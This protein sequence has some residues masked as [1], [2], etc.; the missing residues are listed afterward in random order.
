MDG[1][2]RVSDHAPG[3]YAVFRDYMGA[4]H[5][6]AAVPIDAASGGAALTPAWNALIETSYMIL[7]EAQCEATGLS[8]N[9]YVPALSHSAGAG[10]TGCSGSGT[11]ADEYGAEAARTGW[12]LA[13]HWLLHGD[14]RAALFSRRTAAHVASKLGSFAFSVC[15]SV[16]SCAALQLDTGC[17]I[18]SI[19]PSWVWNGFMLGPTAASLV[20][21]PAHSSALPAQRLAINNAALVLDAMSVDDYY[22]GSWVAIATATLSGV[23]T[24]LAPLVQRLAQTGLPSPPTPLPL[25][26]LLPLPRLPPPPPSRPPSPAAAPTACTARFATCG[27]GHAPCC[28]STA[29]FRQS[30]YYSQCLLSCPVDASPAWACAVPSPPHPSPAESPLPPP[31][32]PVPPPVPQAPVAFRS[33][34]PSPSLPPSPSPS[35]SPLLSASPPPQPPPSSSPSPPLSLPPPSLSPSPAPSLPSLAPSPSPLSLLPSLALP[36]REPPTR[37]PAFIA[38]GFD[39]AMRMTEYQVI[40]TTTAAGAVETF[41]RSSFKRRLAAALPGVRPDDITLRVRAASVRVEAYVSARNATDA[42]AILATLQ[43]LAASTD[44]LS[45]ALGVAVEAVE[46]PLIRITRHGLPAPAAPLPPKGPTSYQM[47]ES[48]ARTSTASSSGAPLA[49]G[50][51]VGALCLLAVV[52]LVVYRRMQHKR[53]SAGRSKAV[54]V[55][56]APGGPVA[57]S[58]RESSGLA[59]DAVPLDSITP[60]PAAP[61]RQKSPHL[62]TPRR[63]SKCAH[64]YV[65]DRIAR[66]RQTNATR[67]ALRPKSEATL[68]AHT[69]A[70]A[71][72]SVS[73]QHYARPVASSS[74]SVR[75]YA[76]PVASPSVSVQHFARAS[77]SHSTHVSAHV[78]HQLDLASVSAFDPNAPPPTM[79]SSQPPC[80]PTAAAE[81]PS[82]ERRR[83]APP[84]PALA[85]IN[86]GESFGDNETT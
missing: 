17:L 21:P 83:H 9:W 73:V 22:S 57:L 43:P 59:V 52:L 66:A 3:H 37:P 76:R 60:A 36:H 77:A 33:W 42:D 69:K 2:P 30:Q 81:S 44:A 27:D 61:P 75:H 4:Y 48:N 26:L 54:T 80:V 7:G 86:S 63:A 15:S 49:I 72:P 51:S 18:N 38:A 85:T 55:V 14:A 41:D 45:R 47:D 11:P 68:S 40:L 12:R 6:L 19:H 46:T 10:T 65:R 74:I 64:S 82:A 50:L 13:V 70:V 62:R 28:A 32:P 35:P 29:C 56:G 8:P 25:P 58:Q 31:P 79:P 24:A 84:F 34:P 39:P 16:A 53:A 78:S 5:T 67:K 1:V 20:V 23:W 71:S